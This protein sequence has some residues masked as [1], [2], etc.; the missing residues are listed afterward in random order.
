MSH[1]IGYLSKGEAPPDTQ[2]Q[3]LWFIHRRGFRKLT[4][5]WW[6]FFRRWG[7]S[8]F[9]ILKDHIATLM[10][11]QYGPCDDF[12]S[13]TASHT[14]EFLAH[15]SNPQYPLFSLKEEVPIKTAKEVEVPEEKTKDILPTKF[16]V[17]P[18]NVRDWLS[19]LEGLEELLMKL[20]PRSR[21][22]PPDETTTQKIVATLLILGDMRPVI[23]CLLNHPA[24]KV[25]FIM[26]EGASLCLFPSSNYLIKIVT[27]LCQ[28]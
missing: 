15:K 5:R 9:V 8:P 16:H 11:Q 24:I 28:S 12:D 26:A 18:Q 14:R 7:K 22:D 20:L 25:A 17:N 3:L 19:C 4:W 21:L 2:L 13:I 6:H 1:I 23:K 27:P 10:D